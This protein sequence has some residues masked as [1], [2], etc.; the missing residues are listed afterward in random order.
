MSLIHEVTANAGTD[1][2]TSA[3]ALEAGGNLAAVKTNTDN[4]DVALSTR[5][6]PADT[7]AAVTSITDPVTVRNTSL[8][9][10]ADYR[11]PRIDMVTHALE[12]IEYEHHEIHN[13]SMFHAE[14][15]NASVAAGATINIYLKTPDTTKWSHIVAK[16]ASGGAAIFR[17]YEAPT[18]TANT[19][20]NGKESFNHNRNSLTASV[21]LDNA[22]V[23][24][25]G[26]YGID[27]TK[28]ADGTLLNT[29]YDGIGK[30]FSGEGEHNNEYM[31]KQNTVYLFEVEAVGN[32][33]TLS[34]NLNW[35]EHT[36]KT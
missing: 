34:L 6:K 2:N 7:L 32:N 8:A 11:S 28:T 3:L 23:P 18:I 29:D 10:D 25:A 5:L 35:Y 30:S 31:L 15:Y 26:K 17:I 19:G 9:S 33:I 21:N 14:N 12:T 22:A 24:V 20:T 13:G 1:L 16:W 4:L 36:N 27:V